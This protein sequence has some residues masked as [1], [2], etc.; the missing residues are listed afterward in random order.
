MPISKE[1]TSLE[2][3]N[4]KLNL[5]IPHED[6]LSQ[7]NE[8]MK[9]HTKNIQLP[10]F[11]KGKVPVNVLERKYGEALK[12]EA[13]GKIVEKT[14]GEVFDSKEMS[15]YEKPLPY[16]RPQMQEE[17]KMEF[18][19]DLTLSLV[20]DVM[21]KITIGQWKEL[22]VEVPQVKVLDEDI[23][24]ELELVRERNSY[25]LDREEDSKAQ[26]SDVVTISY[27]ETGEDGGELPNT[28]RDDFVFTLG[29]KSNAY[30]FDDEIIGMK[31]GE[32]KEFTKARPENGEAVKLNVTLNA[33]K[34]KKIPDLDDELAQDVDEKF[35][36]LDDLKTSI[37]ERLEENLSARIRKVTIEKLLEKIK[38]TT[39]LTLPESMVRAEL[40]GRVRSLAG[41]FGTDTN[42]IME[43]LAQTD[44]GLDNIEKNWRP[45]AEQALKSNLIIDTLIEDNQI[46][47]DDED[48]ENEFKKISLETGA[49]FEDVEN[50]YSN[51]RAIDYLKETI[52]ERKL[53]DLLLS[54][55][56]TKQGIELK[57]IDF[58]GN[59]G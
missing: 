7:Y 47:A 51:D 22:E 15:K 9:E 30:Q 41:Q 21:P 2:K 32:T 57:Y 24:R 39:P 11:R 16:A 28:R 44:G 50:Q 52:K 29:S 13:V 5:T 53:F 37:R 59:N 8:M 6:V 23:L 3:S 1:F 31:K 42:K 10:G 43:M 12:Q 36:T 55:N 26:E 20:Y 40:D 58:L 48:I 18:G 33:L 46:K 14:L 34:E 56:T 49:S 38:E 4:V 54:E 27:F 25:V 45:Q 19:S 17:S 35:N